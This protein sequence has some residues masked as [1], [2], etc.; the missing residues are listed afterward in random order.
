M[1]LSFFSRYRPAAFIL[2]AIAV[3]FM[4]VSFAAPRGALR[5]VSGVAQAVAEGPVAPEFP[6]S[7]AWLNTEKPLSL[8]ALRGKVVLLDFWTY[9]CINCMHILPDLKNLERKYAKELVVISVHSAKFSNEDETQNIRNALLRYN[10][11]HPVLNDVGMKVWEAYGVNAWPTLVVIDPAGRVV[12]SVA[13]EGN[14]DLL[15]KTIGRVATQFKA[16]GKLDTT[17]AR[18]ALEAAKVPTTPLW[19]PGKVLADAEGKRLFIA[20][21]NHNRIVITDLSGNVEA[22]AGTGVAGRKDG[23]F[24]EATFRNPQGMAL[25]RSPGG[26]MTLYVADTNNHLLRALDLKKGTVTTLAGTG[27]QAPWGSRGGLVTAASLAS[28]WDVHIIGEELYIAMAGPH[29]IW[30][31]DLKTQR[32]TPYAGSGREARTDGPLTAAAFAQ[33]SGLATDGKR[34]FVADSEISAIRAVDLPGFG[35]NVRTLAG[36]D[37]F[38]FGDKDGP[39]ATARFQHPLAVVYADGVLYVA[40]TYNHKIKTLNPATGRT[41]TFVGGGSKGPQALFYEPGGLSLANGRLYVAD[42]NNHRIRVVD[43]A[44][45]AVSTLPL[46]NVPAALPAEP[47]RPLRPVASAANDNTITLPPVQLAPDTR[48][49]L[50][51]DV[52]LPPGHK[53]NP[54]SSQRFEARIEGGGVVLGKTVVPT[55]EFTLPLRLPLSSGKAGTSG[56]AVASASIFYC[57]DT[58]GVCK[59]KSLRFRAP[60]TVAK[61]GGRSLTLRTVL[62]K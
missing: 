44:T 46:K 42:T 30:V 9:G 6:A 28:P 23:A 8:R 38:D 34:I 11:E 5:P 51:L 29:Q 35:K 49:E 57:S 47:A 36:G 17:P 16:A 45:K 53:L 48:G 58:Q 19:Y 18:F 21:S 39:G 24:D 20:D 56:V 3:V 2:A 1:K 12:G 50:V 55:A 33:P 41:H 62:E 61:G 7:A 10:I 31:M 37:L 25:R 52:A 54:G 40:D 60:F 43:L 22:V 13:G 14:Y 26:E 59:L 15:D 32:V 27:H 4:V